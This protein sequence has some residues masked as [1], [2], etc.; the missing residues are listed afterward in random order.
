MNLLIRIAFWG[1]AL[2][3]F[4][5]AAVPH[6]PD[7][8]VWDKWQ[9]MAAF[10]VITVLGRAGY[11]RLSRTMLMP[12]LIGFGGLIEL[13]QMIP[14]LHRDSQ[15]SDWVADIFSVIVA[16]VLMDLLE[17]LRRVRSD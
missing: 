10:F 8:H 5:M 2:F 13:V 17:R 15:L 4:V 16:L 14:A 3:A 1:A 11:P 12:A 9:H 7:L 6:P